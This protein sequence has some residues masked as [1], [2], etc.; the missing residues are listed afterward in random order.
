M[1]C[2]GMVYSFVQPGVQNPS[3]THYLLPND[4]SLH[5]RPWIFANNMTK[6]IHLH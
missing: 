5:L 2:I 1:A 3:K 6:M 4:K